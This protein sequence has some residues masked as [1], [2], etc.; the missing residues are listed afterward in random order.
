MGAWN[1]GVYDNDH[2]L[3]L[4]SIEVGSLVESLEEVLA[5]ENLAFDD[6]EGPL[7][8][9]DLLGMIAKVATVDLA[10]SR[11][12]AWKAT[13]LAAFDDTIGEVTAYVKKRRR[14]IVKTFDALASCLEDDK[15]PPKKTKKK[16]RR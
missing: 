13:Y 16:S 10:R 8:Y 5:I 14:V 7:I 6:L 15:P 9:V 2:A 4:L 11:V 1:V 12:T 3:D